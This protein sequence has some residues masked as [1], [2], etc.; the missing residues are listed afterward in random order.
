MSSLNLDR[1]AGE[2]VEY[3]AVYNVPLDAAIDHV[4]GGDLHSRAL[5]AVK[6][7]IARQF[8]RRGE[9]DADAISRLFLREAV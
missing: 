7:V 4:S 9:S 6:L 3:S 2:I 5:G 1:I 8:Q